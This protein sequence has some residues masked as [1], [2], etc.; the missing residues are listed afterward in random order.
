L[1]PYENVRIVN[2]V[3]RYFAL[4]IAGKE[5]FST[6]LTYLPMAIVLLMALNSSTTGIA[7]IA[8]NSKRFLWKGFSVSPAAMKT[9][10]IY[11][12]IQ[13]Y[14]M[15]IKSLY[16]YELPILIFC[17]SLLAVVSNFATLTMYDKVELP[18]YVCAPSLSIIV[19]V[20][21]VTLVPQA[22][23]VFENC[24]AYRKELKITVKSKIEKAVLRS[25]RPFGIHCQLFMM[26]AS[27]R[28][29]IIQYQTNYT[30]TL[31]ISMK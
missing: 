15:V 29:Q 16:T 27:I 26:R 18:L 14:L 30:M 6:A 12:M 13:V 7:K 31:L 19:I 28:P 20:L 11:K 9:I 3:L 22:H 5:I 25:L 8:R 24:Q 2:I 10:K 1:L 17:G 4:Y 23:N 21:I